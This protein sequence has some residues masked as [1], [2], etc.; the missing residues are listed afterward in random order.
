MDNYNNWVK[1]LMNEGKYKEAIIKAKEALTLK[2][3]DLNL[4]NIAQSYLR[5][6]EYD[7]ALKHFKRALEINPEDEVLRTN[8][9]KLE[10]Y[11]ANEK[12]NSQKNQ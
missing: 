12:I 1:A 11:I 8:L 7:L 9:E 2:E 3:D 5:M 6:F 10:T 4:K